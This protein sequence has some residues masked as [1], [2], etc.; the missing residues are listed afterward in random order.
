MMNG[1]KRAR[2]WV[3]DYLSADVPSRLIPYRTHW[4][5]DDTTLPNPE[6]YL[7]YEPVA[8][9]HW[10]M[11]YTVYLATQN[12]VRDDYDLDENPKYTVTGA[13]RTYIWAKSETSEG[14]SDLRDDLTTVVRDALLDGPAVSSY[15]Q[16]QTDCSGVIDEASIREEFS[17]LTPLKGERMLAGAYLQYNL[18]MTEVVTRAPLGSG[19]VS[20]IPMV[21]VN[22]IEKVPNAP[23]LLL[24][25][26]GS[27]AGEVDLTWRAP[28][29]DGGGFPLVG[30]TIEQ[31]DDDGATWAI[32]ISDTGT[33]TPMATVT[34]LTTG[35]IYLFRVSAINGN[36]TGA[37][38]ASSV[39]TTAP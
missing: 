6:L 32:S 9:D 18:D 25:V 13:M 17:D 38:S 8:I 26:D 22:L 30:Y 35:D 31:S 27:S 23:T 10:P 34:G 24:T 3:N 37:T 4:G 29:W 19:I 16:T 33:T 21:M 39:P 1:P 7:T 2:H 15:N 12:I 20:Q 11:I 36:G 14:A 28:T 5:L